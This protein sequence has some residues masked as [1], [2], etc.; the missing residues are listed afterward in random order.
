[1]LDQSF[2]Y[3]NF[4]KIFVSENKKGNINRGYINDEYLAKHE[5]FK[6]IL[7]EKKW[8]KTEKG[9]LSKEEY[10]QF[11]EKLEK[12]N[13]GKEEIRLNEFKKIAESVAENSFQ[14]NIKYNSDIEIFTINSNNATSF[15]AIKQ[16]QYNIKKTF[17]VKQSSRNDI[18]R[19]IYYLLADGFPKIVIRTD[20]SSFYES[21]PQNIL[22]EK[23]N[24]NILLSPHSKK[25]IRKLFYEFE[26]KK[27]ISKIPLGAGIPRGIGISAYLSELFMRDIDNEIKNIQ[28]LTYYARYVDDIIMIFTPKTVSSKVDYL[29]KVRTIITENQLQLNEGQNGKECKTYETNLLAD[30]PFNETLTFLGYKFQIDRTGKKR[31]TVKIELSDHK[32]NKYKKRIIRSIDFYNK[33]APKNEKRARNHLSDRLKFLTGNFHLLHNKKQIKSGIFY[34]N[35]LLSLNTDGDL[36]SLK[37]SNLLSLKRLNEEL[38]NAVDNIAVPVFLNRVALKKHILDN[39][40]FEKGFF[41]KEKYFY[42]FSLSQKERDFYSQKYGRTISKFEIIK[43]IWKDE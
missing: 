10:N 24:N 39:F 22:F 17:K 35:S 42:S 16:L 7:A 31:F 41:N 14:F 20:I 28:D 9:N 8:L 21:I 43:S 5:E 37:K 33:F 29:S 36:E 6:E 3:Y 11:A 12:I 4:N 32:L 40:N 13:Q 15:Y 1:M 30:T 18:V 25:L 27:D 19:Q 23:I 2:S 34:S 38:E 26:N